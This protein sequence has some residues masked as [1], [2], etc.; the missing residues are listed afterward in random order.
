M[1]EIC[2]KTHRIASHTIDPVFRKL[3]KEVVYIGAMNSNEFTYDDVSEVIRDKIVDD[4]K[5]K[6]QIDEGKGYTFV[7]FFLD[8]LN[9]LSSVGLISISDIIASFDMLAKEAAE[10]LEITPSYVW[11]ADPFHK[12]ILNVNKSEDIEKLKNVIEFLNSQ[13][14]NM[15]FFDIRS[16]V[17]SFIRKIDAN[18]KNSYPKFDLQKENHPDADQSFINAVDKKINEVALYGVDFTFT[19]ASANVKFFVE[20]ATKTLKRAKVFGS[21]MDQ[22]FAEN[23]EKLKPFKICLAAVLEKQF[24]RQ[25]DPET[26]QEYSDE[27]IHATSQL[28]C[29]LLVTKSIS[30]EKVKELNEL[31]KSDPNPTSKQCNFLM[32]MAIFYCKYYKPQDEEPAST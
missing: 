21:F 15:D 22:I 23:P 29:E 24:R 18:I 7:A 2:A 9:E 3:C 1:F 25:H 20:N 4:F 30:V 5:K 32:D 13:L 8:Y 16:Q 11:F 19:N 14:Y 10:N 6:A 26:R 28:I 31:V 27:E 17:R 12:L